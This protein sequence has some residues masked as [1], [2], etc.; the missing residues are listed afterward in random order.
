MKTYEDLTDFDKC[1][2]D[3]LRQSISFVEIAAILKT[4]KGVVAGKSFRLKH[5]IREQRIQRPKVKTVFK[6]E[7]KK[8][9]I[10]P[11]KKP[12]L[13]EQKDKIIALV[14]QGLNYRQIT[15]AL[16]RSSSSHMA[17]WLKKNGLKANKEIKLEERPRN[18]INHD[19]VN[20]NLYPYAKPFLQITDEICGYPL[21]G[22]DEKTGLVCGDEI[23]IGERYCQKCK[24]V[25][26]TK[27]NAVE[28]KKSIIQPRR[29]F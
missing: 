15:K 6:I 4:T 24:Q 18:L 2:V 28:H 3:L 20:L 27:P 23:K 5:L 26:Y 8:I 16:G 11:S 19:G 17:V 12:T 9:I 13:D 21:W 7:K 22:S 29:I 10:A 14:N 25:V 1:C